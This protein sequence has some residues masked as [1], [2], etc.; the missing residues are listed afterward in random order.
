R[1]VRTVVQPA[2][3]VLLQGR[4]DVWQERA[5]GPALLLDTGDAIGRALELAHELLRLGFRADH[6]LRL[7]LRRFRAGRRLAAQAVE[8]SHEVLFRILLGQLD[9]NRPGLDRHELPDLLLA[10]AYEA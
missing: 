5:L 9:V 2:R 6:E 8:P 4:R 10:V 1:A 3:R 7:V